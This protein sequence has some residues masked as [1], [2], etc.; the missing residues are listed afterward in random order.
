MLL[1]VNSPV[2]VSIIP[3]VVLVCAVW[4]LQGLVQTPLGVAE[5][6]PSLDLGHL[7]LRQVAVGGGEIV[8]GPEVRIVKLNF[9]N[10]VFGEILAAISGY[11][12]YRRF[13]LECK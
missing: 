5:E 1:T 3:L 2:Q 9:N 4:P 12:G 8:I 7:Q 10:N 13:S 6:V 11:S